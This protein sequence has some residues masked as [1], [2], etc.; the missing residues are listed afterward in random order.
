MKTFKKIIDISSSLNNDKKLSYVDNT[1]Y[2]PPVNKSIAKYI[3]RIIEEKIET[4]N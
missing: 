2:S 4:A 1:N 3:Y